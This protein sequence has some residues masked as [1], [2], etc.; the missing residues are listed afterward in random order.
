MQDQLI[1]ISSGGGNAQ[2][3]FVVLTLLMMLFVIELQTAFSITNVIVILT[4]LQLQH[5]L[6]RH[7]RNGI[8]GQV[9]ERFE[10]G[11]RICCLAEALVE[12]LRPC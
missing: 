7:F 12:D 9:E 5:R 2:Q 4:M 8:T 6:V 10:I 1:I 11:L 3:V